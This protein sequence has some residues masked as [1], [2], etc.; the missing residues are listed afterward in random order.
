LRGGGPKGLLV[1]QLQR[2]ADAGAEFGILYNYAEDVG[3]TNSAPGGDA[4][5]PLGGTDYLPMP[6]MFIGHTDGE[7]LRTWL[8]TNAAARVRMRLNSVAQSLTVTS[9][10]ICEHVGVRI[11]TDHPLRGDLRFT[12][13]SPGG[14]RSVLQRFNGDLNPGPLDW[15]Y[16]STHH[17]GESSLGTWTLAASDELA[18]AVGSIL[19][20]TLIVR[21]V[22]ILDSDADGLDDAWE[23]DYWGGLSLGPQDDPDSDGYLNA[24]EQLASQDPGRA[25]F[26]LQVDLGL[27]NEGMVRLGWPGR[28]GLV[29]EVLSGDDPGAL[30]PQAEVPAHVPETEWFAPLETDSPRFFQVRAVP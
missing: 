26:P 19:E 13:L 12:L 21:G 1:D 15:T 16:W 17:L 28:P 20:I 8:Q 4:L 7:H 11:K 2:A 6:V 23:V 3:D 30:T 27:W 10:L 25:D 18:E 22:P 9:P 5:T 29:Y 14:T 24:F